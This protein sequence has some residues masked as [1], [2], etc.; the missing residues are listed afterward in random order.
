MRDLEMEA[1]AAESSISTVCMV[2]Y[3]TC[4]NSCDATEGKV[5]WQYIGGPSG[6]ASCRHATTH[7][8]CS[9]HPII[10]CKTFE[11]HAHA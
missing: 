3:N 10:N 11:V 1:L 7:S 2:A 9:C 8:L 6:C 5:E 4:N